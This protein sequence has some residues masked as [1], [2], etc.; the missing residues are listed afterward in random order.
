MMIANAGMDKNVIHFD[1]DVSA[2]LFDGADV[3]RHFWTLCRHYVSE[4][5]LTY[6][7][8]ASSVMVLNSL[9]VPSPDNPQIYP[10]KEFNQEN[11]FTDEVLHVRR[12]LE[13]E[14]NGSTLDQLADLLSVF[15]VKVDRHFADALDADECRAALVDAMRSS[16]KRVIVDFNRKTLGQKGAGHF[17]PLAAYH[18][19]ED[20]FLVMDVARYKLPPFWVKNDLLRHAMDSVDSVSGK[21]RGFL[22]ISQK[23]TSVLSP[24]G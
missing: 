5:F 23:P 1:E 4:K 11:I 22:V 20:R 16:D 13:I 15:P 3:K 9:D 7:G 24:P 19:G 17:S 21:S 18:A 12:P 8:V 6:C 14:K 2:A 10:Y